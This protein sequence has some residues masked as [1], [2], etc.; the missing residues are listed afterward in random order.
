MSDQ[1]ILCLVFKTC[2]A[3]S[4]LGVTGSKKG[5]RKEERMMSCL[6]STFGLVLEQMTSRITS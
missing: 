6:E 1:S 3:F 4:D 2:G 5:N